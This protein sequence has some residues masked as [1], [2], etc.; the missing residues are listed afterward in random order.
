MADFEWDEEK[1][2]LNQ[3]KH[4]ISFEEATEVFNGD[5]VT[6]E[7][8]DPYDELREKT[9]GLVRAVLVVCVAHTDR[10]GVIRIISA[11][12]ATK[13]ERDLYNAHLR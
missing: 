1:N 12:K 3:A 9:F 6:I 13:S 8:A 5:H 7:D 4:R 10:D 11:R 2:R